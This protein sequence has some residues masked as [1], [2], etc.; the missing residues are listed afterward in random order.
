MSIIINN[1]FSL[2]ESKRM[3][4]AFVG[5]PSM[6]MAPI[7][8]NLDELDADIA[9]IGMPYDLGTSV[10]PGARYAPR[11]L[12]DAS[13]LVNNYAFEG[14]YDPIR[15]EHY[16]GAP[17]K[18][19][20]CGD[21][22]V[23]H[24]YQEQSFK[25]CE[26]AVRKILSKGAIPFVLG[27]DHA[28]TTPVLR[29]FDCYED[30]CVIQFD[31]HMDF[32]FAPFGIRE[33]QGSPMRRA[34]EM[35][36]IGKLMQIGIRGIGSSQ[37][38]D[39]EDAKRYGSK[40]VTSREVRVKGVDAVIDMLPDARKYYIT[41]DIDGLDPTI[42]SGTGSPQ[43][44]GLYYE[45][46]SDIIEGVAQKGEV[47]GFDLVEVSPPYDPNQL[48]ASYGAQIILDAMSF[49]LKEKERQQR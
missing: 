2:D 32:T 46:V 10:R 9:V 5:I 18:I 17:W 11:G 29:A 40:I 8:L 25:N 33:G 24:T 31:A 48:T 35:K 28:V 13:T 39:I 37:V 34:S 43:A 36:H 21:I 19:V 3:R 47:V 6:F 20:D 22:D 16:L 15:E 41:V 26:A 30:V 38:S 42:S 7:C 4:N 1:P 27:G 49:I 45:E 12:R 14:W 44:F 23:M